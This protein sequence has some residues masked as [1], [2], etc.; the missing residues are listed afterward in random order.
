MLFV[1]IGLLL[2]FSM[3]LESVRELH[4]FRITHYRVVSK[5]LTLLKKDK[6]ILFLSD[7]HNKSYGMGNE[8][9]YHAIQ[10]EAPDYILVGGDMLVGQRGNYSEH[11]LELLERL[12]KLCPVYYANG[13]HEQRMKEDPE[14]YGTIFADY[15]KRLERAGVVFLENQTIHLDV[16]GM[17]CSVSGLELPMKYYEKF[18][19]YRVTV[20][21]VLSCIGHPDP[22]KFQILLAHNPA[23][24]DTYKKWGADLILSGHLHG[25]IIRIPGIGGCISPQVIP[26]PKYSGEMTREDDC[27]IIVSRGLG[28]HTV[29]IRLFNTAELVV[30]KLCAP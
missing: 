25:G 15:K 7:L 27:T 1:L 14:Y 4:M 26:F 8:K 20:S 10:K 2:V 5:K 18:H 6:N 29:N 11:A 30:V 24:F 12:P 16:D 3:L 9:L 19:R 28:T 21:E 13:N 22:E 17:S 23:F